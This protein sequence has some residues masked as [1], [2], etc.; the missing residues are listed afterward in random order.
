MKV[1]RM[2]H[3]VLTV[4]D[5]GVSVAFYQRVLGMS[6]ELFGENRVA[7]S[8]GEQKINLHELGS[9]FEP[10]AGAVQVGS[11]DLCFLLETPLQ[12]AVTH[13]ESCGVELLQGPVKRTGALGPIL[14]LYFR[15]PDMNLIEVSNYL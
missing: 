3:L 10:K 6:K 15:D 12:E 7:L 13:I 14:S 8:F 5:I 9:E 11:A 4:N 1:K 2:D